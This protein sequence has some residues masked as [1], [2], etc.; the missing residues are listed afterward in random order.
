MNSHQFTDRAALNRRIRQVLSTFRSI[1]THM[2]THGQN[3][4]ESS[5]HLAGRI[6][7][8]GRAALAPVGYGMDLESLV[9]DELTAH[10]VIKGGFV[11]SGPTVRL[12]ESSAQLMSLAVHELATNSVKYGALSQP[13]ARLRV[14]WRQTIREDVLRLHFEWREDG[15]EMTGRPRAVGFGSDVVE[16]LIA[17]ELRGAGEI[18]FSPNGVCCTIE[19][20]LSEAP[21]EN[22]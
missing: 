16:R 2:A 3:P 11:V 22:E 1:A 8:I 14:L 10:A 9:L 20:P 6:G 7:A 12:P 17:R 5:L 15:V 19:V 13:G 4:E 21:T 18:V